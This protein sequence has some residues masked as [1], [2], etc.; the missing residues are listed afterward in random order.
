M[1][2]INNE[3]LLRSPEQFIST[4]HTILNSRMQSSRFLL[5]GEGSIL[6]MCICT[7]VCI[8]HTSGMCCVSLIVT[9]TMYVHAHNT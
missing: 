1:A 6:M 8:G 9:Y 2:Y 3:Q 5:I 4:K 7:Y